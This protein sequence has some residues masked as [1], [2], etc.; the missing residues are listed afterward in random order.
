MKQKRSKIPKKLMLLLVLLSSWSFTFAQKQITGTIINGEDNLPLIGGTVMIKGTTTGTVTDFDGKYTIK[1]SPEDTIVFSFFGLETQEIAVGSQTTIDITLEVKTEIL[2]EAVVI[3]YGIKKKRDVIG[4]VASVDAKKLEEIE[5][6]NFEEALQG[7]ATG[8]QV[9]SSGGQPGASTRILVRGVNSIN[10][11]TEPL[12]IIDGIAVDGDGMSTLNPNDI[13]SINVLKDASATA[14]YG[15]RGSNGVIIVTTKSGKAG[16][17]ELS[18][19]YSTGFSELTRTPDEVGFANTE[20]WF[21][22]IETGMDNRY[23]TTG[24]KFDPSSNIGKF[25]DYEVQTLSREE[26]GQIDIDWFDQMLRT[27]TFN[28]F[29]I[30]NA[31]GFEKGNIFLSLNYRDDKG[32]L[33]DDDFKRLSGRININ[34]DPFKNMK[35]GAKVNVS[36]TDRQAV[37]SY[38]TF[39]QAASMQ[40]PWYAIYSDSDPSTSNYL[41]SN[42]LYWNPAGWQAYNIAAYMDEDLYR[43]TSETYRGLGSLFLNYDFKWDK[44]PWLKGLSARS[45]V[46]FDIRQSNNLSWTSWRL[47]RVEGENK[48]ETSSS[49]N[50]STRNNYNYNLYFSYDRRMGTDNN[51]DGYKDHRI[52]FVVGTEAQRKFKHQRNL[53]ANYL[54]G[55]NQEIGPSPPNTDLSVASYLTGENYLGAYFGRADYSFKDKYYIGASFRRD[56]SSKFTPEYRWGTFTAYSLGWIMTDESFIKALLKEDESKRIISM[57][58]LR[59]SYGQTGNQNVPDYIDLTTFNTAAGN[60]YGTIDQGTTLTSV[61]VGDVTWET[62]SSY[63]G[64]IDYSLL[65]NRINGS[66]A[67]YFQDVD[68]LILS[69][70]VPASSGL[71][72]ASVKKNV[73][74]MLNQGVEFNISSTNIRKYL[75]KKEFIWTTDFNITTNKNE[76]KYL[77]EDI[78]ASNGGISS[79]YTRTKVGTQ[80]G[81]IFMPEFAGIDKE[82][83][84]EMIYAIDYDHYLKT[85][86]TVKLQDADG[87]YVLVPA[88]DD[89]LD[90]HK[91]LQEDKTGLPKFFGG[92]SNSFEY[93]GFSVGVMI[94]FAGGNYI[95]DYPE[96]RTTSLGVGNTVLRSDLIGNTWTPDNPD[97]K[98]PELRYEAN[99]QWD[100]EGNYVGKTGASYDRI[101]GY[102]DKFLYKG[103]YARLKRVQIGYNFPKPILDKLKMNGLRIYASATNLFTL[104]YYKGFDPEVTSTIGNT[105]LGVGYIGGYS[106]PH[107]RTYSFG[108]SIKL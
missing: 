19:N 20:E 40:L 88:T 104:S 6:A 71:S 53:S 36:Y 8:L 22:L 25:Q 5:T 21:S 52:N 63:D 46:S 1:A 16:K 82:T 79:G 102:F 18:V 49:D 38:Y 34:V 12:W 32:M 97:A 65:R 58:K 35:V 41:P 91:M 106:L 3:G 67:Y 44:A 95:Y 23:G 105:N 45:E 54:S 72:G 83:G 50:V 94:T 42:S 27:G 47:D 75:G 93:A 101:S 59:G 2:E 84:I 37:N 30:S 69:V 26:A 85:N 103:D 15:S 51:G 107:L 100:S 98:Y 70:P 87:N 68:G 89:N 92:F 74:R 61:G 80:L 62:T 7:N 60:S 4:S 86:E 14:I 55:I 31:T 66:L 17:N 108:V 39:N 43:N 77:T 28:D 29:N 78:E 64:G 11:G 57:L 33:K 96:Q 10:S 9:S 90:K 76:V 13:A 99:Y 81:C 48:S 24:N 73:G 56:A